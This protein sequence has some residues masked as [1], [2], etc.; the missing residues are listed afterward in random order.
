MLAEE[1]VGVDELTAGVV[2]EEDEVL[3]HANK[4]K[5]ATLSGKSFK[6]L[7]FI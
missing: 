3:L 2:D 1:L 6:I 5:A 7:V 4:S